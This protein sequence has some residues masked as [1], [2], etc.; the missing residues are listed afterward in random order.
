MLGHKYKIS[1]E[2]KVACTKQ[3]VQYSVNSP[4]RVKIITIIIV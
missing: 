2:K 1:Y 3:L 4:S